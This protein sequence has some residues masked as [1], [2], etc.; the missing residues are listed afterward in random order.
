PGVKAVLALSPYS[1]PF[2]VHRT[3][4][5]L[6]APVMYQGGTLD[7][8]ITPALERSGGSY[9]Q[10]SAPKYFVELEGAGHF[11]WPDAGLRSAH[12]SIVRYSVAF[13]DHHL[14]GAP[15]DPVLTHTEPDVV[16]L[17][18]D[19]DVGRGEAGSGR[20]HR[21]RLKEHEP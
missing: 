3:L 10:S 4:G 14:K 1:Q 20:R 15:A 8:A 2:L 13:L 17:R 16:L 21:A 12:D 6:A 7:L 5:G 18:Y 11:A 19:S 9:D